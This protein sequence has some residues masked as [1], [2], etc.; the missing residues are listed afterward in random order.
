VTDGLRILFLLAFGP[1]DQFVGGAIG[2]I[3]DRLDAVLAQSDEHGRGEARHFS[4]FVGHAKFAALGVALGF[5]LLQ[6]FAGAVLDFGCRV[7]VETLDVGDFGKIDERDF[8][9]RGEAFGDEQLGD[10]LI[11]VERFHEESRAL[12]E[13]LLTPLALFLLG[14]NIDVPAGQLR[15]K[16]HVLAAPADSEREL[17]FGHHDFDAV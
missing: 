2:E 12:G 4:Q 16:P 17:R 1:A 10:D 11:D 3:L 8:L 6:I 7:L 13:F 15:G 5:L 9:D 14:Q